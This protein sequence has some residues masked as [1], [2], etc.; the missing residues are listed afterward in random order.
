M[1]AV[2]VAGVQSLRV[3]GAKSKSLCVSFVKYGVRQANKK[4][5]TSLIWTKK[6]ILIERVIHLYVAEENWLSLPN[7]GHG[8][9]DKV[10]SGR[11]FA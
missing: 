9:I 2:I 8:R 11:P 7:V 6:N 5:L 1:T 4:C 10:N 3:L